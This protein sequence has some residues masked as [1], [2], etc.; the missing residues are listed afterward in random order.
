MCSAW[1]EWKP[2]A[3]WDTFKWSILGIIHII[4]MLNKTKP[5]IYMNGIELF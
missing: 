5:K 3:T 4:L 2:A 1:L